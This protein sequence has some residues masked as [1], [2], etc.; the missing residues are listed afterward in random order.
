[1]IREPVLCYVRGNLA[2][3][4]SRELAQQW[5]DNWGSPPYQDHAGPPYEWHEKDKCEPFGIVKVAFDGELDSPCD[6]LGY[7][8]WSVSQI[9]SGAVAWLASPRWASGEIV[10]IPAGVTI[11]RFSEL[12]RKAGGRVYVEARG[13]T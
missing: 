3:F 12:V 8:G 1:M 10:A 6:V 13:G 2:Y 11:E 7:G 9:N 4:T 5:G